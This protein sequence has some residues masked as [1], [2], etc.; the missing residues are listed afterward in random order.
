MLVFV[1]LADGRRLGRL[2]SLFSLESTHTRVLTRFNLVSLYN[3]EVAA[4][5]V[6]W[7][8]GLWFDFWLCWSAAEVSLGKKRNLKLFPGWDYQKETVLNL[9]SQFVNSKGL[10]GMNFNQVIRNRG[11]VWYTIE[12]NPLLNRLEIWLGL[13]G[14]KKVRKR[15]GFYLAEIIFFLIFFNHCK[16]WFWL[17]GLDMRDPSRVNLGPL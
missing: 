1:W 10:F 12:Q 9:P 8:K 11:S 17:N 16:F 15:S 7:P 14:T 3:T 13:N 5:L 2:V 6:E 4:Q